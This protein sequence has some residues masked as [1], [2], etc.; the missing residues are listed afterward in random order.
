MPIQPEHALLRFD[1]LCARAYRSRDGEGNVD[2]GPC[3]NLATPC[4]AAHQPSTAIVPST[5]EVGAQM[6]DFWSI[7]SAVPP[8]PDV[9]Q[10][11]PGR[12][13]MTQVG[14]DALLRNDPHRSDRIGFRHP[15]LPLRP[16][17]SSLRGTYVRRR[18]GWAAMCRASVTGGHPANRSGTSNR[19]RGGS[20]PEGDSKRAPEQNAGRGGRMAVGAV[21]A[22]T[23]LCRKHARYA[24]GQTD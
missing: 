9:R 4:R 15:G 2:Y 8:T 21:C 17:G 7:A 14:S 16:G 13:C 5:P 12:Q 20:P 3:R 23:T 22:L 18:V 10:R 19:A 11:T 24:I 6:S 1:P